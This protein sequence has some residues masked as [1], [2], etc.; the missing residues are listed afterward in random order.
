M[1]NGEDSYCSC[2]VE[3]LPNTEIMREMIAWCLKV[4]AVGVSGLENG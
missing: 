3:S 1:V 2:R 4:E